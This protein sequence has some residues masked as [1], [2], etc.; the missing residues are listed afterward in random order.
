[1]TIE[2]RSKP[3]VDTMHIALHNAKNM[4]DFADYVYDQCCDW[5]GHN[6]KA[7]SVTIITAA[8][9]AQ[10]DDMREK[11][12]TAVENNDW[13]GKSNAANAMAREIRDLK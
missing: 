1:M 7:W 3:T 6:H 11:A 2:E 8:L 5:I 10:R 4:E 12:A 13:F 9:Q